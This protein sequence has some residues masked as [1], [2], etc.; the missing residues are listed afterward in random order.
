MRRIVLQILA[1]MFVG[2]YAYGST[3]DCW[4][5][6]DPSAVETV[7][8]QTC[9]C[10]PHLKE[11]QLDHTP[12]CDDPKMVCAVFPPEYNILLPKTV[13]HPPKATA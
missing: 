11:V 9:T 12:P 6:C 5:T 3:I 13:F 7:V 10:R 1:L 4:S 2:V 8:C